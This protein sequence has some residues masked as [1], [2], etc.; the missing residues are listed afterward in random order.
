MDEHAIP[1]ALRPLSRYKICPY[2]RSPLP[3]C[4]CAH[5]SSHNISKIIIY[6]SS[7]YISC[8]IYCRCAE[9]DRGL[10]NVTQD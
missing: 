10:A 3:E 2:L 4:Y 6:C 7:D 1:S 8:Q 9:A 5:L